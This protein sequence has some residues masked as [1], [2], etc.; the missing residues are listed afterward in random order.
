[1]AK[2]RTFGVLLLESS[3]NCLGSDKTEGWHGKRPDQVAPQPGTFRALRHTHLSECTGFL[4]L[5]IQGVIIQVISKFAFLPIS[6]ILSEVNVAFFPHCLMLSDVFFARKVNRVE[7]CC[8]GL[9]RS[10]ND[11]IF[12]CKSVA[13]FKSRLHAAWPQANDQFRLAEIKESLWGAR[14]RISIQLCES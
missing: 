13:C 5:D 8:R 3:R 9:A 11:L 4:V 2:G 7:A 14:S 12:I 10:N 1:M 6:P